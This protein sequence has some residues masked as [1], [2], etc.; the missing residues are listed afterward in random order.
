M[1]IVVLSVHVLHH[2]QAHLILLTGL[3]L[4]IALTTYYV[5]RMHT[6]LDAGLVVNLLITVKE[7]TERL[8]AEVAVVVQHDVENQ[9]HTSG[10]D[11]IQQALECHVFVAPP[12]LPALIAQVHLGEVHGVIAVVVVTRRILHHGGYPDSRETQ[13]LDIVQT[14]Y[15]SL[16]VTT[17]TRVFGLLLC[18][19]VLPAQHIVGGVA[20]IK[21]GCYHKIDGLVAEVGPSPYKTVGCPDSQG[22]A[23]SYGCQ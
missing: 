15:K 22:Q 2:G 17:P 21:T 20:V 23:Q 14:L 18:R 4:P 13:G 8:F 16:E 1:A 7:A 9:F 19:L 11:G 12:L 3:L 6:T 10:M 5:K